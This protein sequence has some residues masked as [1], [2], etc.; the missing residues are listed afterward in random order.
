MQGPRK[1]DPGQHREQLPALARFLHRG[2]DPRQASCVNV[3]SSFVPLAC[4]HLLP[5]VLTDH[6]SAAAVPAEAAAA[7]GEE[8]AAV[9]TGSA[10]AAATAAGAATATEAGA[11]T[12]VAVASSASSA[13]N[14]CFK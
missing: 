4:A 6:G 5:L 8:E 1:D 9:A 14:F 7:A 2:Y 12:A 3:S 13:R 11:M 10:A